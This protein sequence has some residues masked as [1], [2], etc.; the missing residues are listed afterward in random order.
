[1]GAEKCQRESKWIAPKLPPPV[2]TRRSAEAM[3]PG[4]DPA[5]ALQRTTGA[6]AAVRPADILALQRLI[7]NRAVQRLLAGRLDQK[8]NAAT[9]DHFGPR[10]SNG[11][12]AGADIAVDR[13]GASAG[14]ALPNDIRGRFEN[15][16]GADLS[17]VRVHTGSES[18]EA[19][20]AVGAKAYTVGQ[21]IHFG[22]GHYAPADPTGVH[23][24]A[25]EVAHTVQN[26]GTVAARL[27]TLEVS[28]PA[29]AAEVEANRAADAMIARTPADVHQDD[30]SS[31]SPWLGRIPLGSTPKAIAR[32]PE[33]E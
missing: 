17:G 31:S 10:D 19:A 3:A 13:A 21:D 4:I 32:V 25:H 24:L 20:T 15:S 9:A 27:S 7:G 18:A 26:Q 22:A 11:V 28:T 33:D 23:L 29:D 12:A 8:P 14:Q 16:L 30:K 2:P 1:M 5:M 6:P